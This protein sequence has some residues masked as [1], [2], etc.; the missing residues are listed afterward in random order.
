MA[1]QSAFAPLHFGGWSLSSLQRKT[2]TG[3]VVQAIFFKAVI[4][5]NHLSRGE[6]RLQYFRGGRGLPQIR[7]KS[8]STIPKWQP[9]FGPTAYKSWSRDKW[10]P[11]IRY[12]Y[13]L[14]FNYYFFFYFFI[15]STIVY[16]NNCLP[17]GPVGLGYESKTE[18]NLGFYFLFTPFP[19]NYL[20][21]C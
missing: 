6:E 19:K 16:Q 13:Y 10:F 11:F 17:G 2:P 21:F 14:D 9:S 8:I 1:Y 3:Q 20:I 15:S 18:R 7:L 12:L 4:N 5:V